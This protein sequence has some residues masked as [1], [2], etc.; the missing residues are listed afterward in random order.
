MSISKKN[1]LIA[2]SGLDL[3]EALRE[4]ELIL[5]SLRN[6][7]RACCHDIDTYKNETVRF[8]DDWGVTHRLAKVREILSRGFDSE[9][10]DDDMDDLERAME[11]LVYWEEPNQKSLPFFL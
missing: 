5:I 10:G 2:M 4:L 7:G 1:K 9:L 3:I 11:D 8:I 6:I